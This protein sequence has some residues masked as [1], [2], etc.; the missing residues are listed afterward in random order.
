[1][2]AEYRYCPGLYEFM[3]LV[4]TLCLPPAIYVIICIGLR[5]PTQPP[6]LTT[7]LIRFSLYKPFWLTF[8]YVLPRLLFT[9][10]FY[11]FGLVSW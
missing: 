5:K 9:P 6:T 2:V 7:E 4:R 8:R 11:E 10:I 3:R 1:M